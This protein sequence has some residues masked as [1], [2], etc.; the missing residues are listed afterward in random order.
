MPTPVG[1]PSERE[2]SLTSIPTASIL[3]ANI[4]YI[5]RCL[6]RSPFAPPF[7]PHPEPQ[8]MHKVFCQSRVASAHGMVRLLRKPQCMRT[9]AT[10]ASPDTLIFQGT[11]ANPPCSGTVFTCCPPIARAQV[12]VHDFLDFSP[13]EFKRKGQAAVASCAPAASMPVNPP[14]KNTSGPWTELYSASNGSVSLR[15]RKGP[16]L[17]S[18]N[19]P[20]RLTNSASRTLVCGQNGRGYR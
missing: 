20:R 8:W 14:A 5:L 9:I 18:R 10:R 19:T 1:F 13:P 16:R 17:G 3:T 15:V 11:A 2:V 7:S 4:L 6:C 12:T